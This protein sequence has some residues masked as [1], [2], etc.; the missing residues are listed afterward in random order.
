MCYP[1][2][3]LLLFFV[4]SILVAQDSAPLQTT[5]RVRYV[6]DSSIYIEGGRNAG[7]TEGTKLVIKQSTQK[8]ATDNT[9]KSIEPGIVAEL[10]VVSV[11]ATSA[12][13]DVV[14]TARPIV[15]G[16]EVSLPQ[17]EVQKIV[18]KQTLSNSRQYPAV[19]SFSEGD[20]LDED[21]REK[22]PRP[23][24]PEVNQARGRIG[25]D[26]STIRTI[27]QAQGSSTEVGLVIRADVTRIHGTHWNLNGYWRGRLERSSGGT[28]TLQDQIN[29]TYL[30]GLTY[31]N[32]ESRWSAGVGRLYLPW[33]SSLQTIDGGYIGRKV[34]DRVTLAAFGG[35]TPDPT[36]WNYDP[37]RRIG[38]GLL[39]VQG[40]SFE[41]LW[42][43]SSVGMGMSFL[44]T[45]LDRPFVF[46]E[47][48]FSY[49]RMFSVYHSMQIDRPK[50]N[51]G[52]TPVPMGLGQSFFTLRFQPI[53]R[54]SLDANH[55]YFRDVPTYDP[56]LLGTG[57]LDKYLFQGFSAGAR[58]ELPLHLAAYG[59][60][61][62][63]SNS[64][65]AHTS[66]NSMY[67]LTLQQ[68]WRTGVR[69]DARYSKFDSSFANGTYRSLS[70]ERNFGEL[71]RWNIQFGQQSF[72]SSFSKD[73][74]GR[75]LNSYVD[76]IFGPHYFL[77]SGLTVQRGSTENYNQ[78]TTTVGYRFNNRSRKKGGAIA[79]PQH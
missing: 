68:L 61:G 14:S 58:V 39:N 16:D 44:G 41:T 65:D 53:Q 77:E 4:P 22:M 54:L 12:V 40:G 27:G 63:S 15:E 25:F 43:S 3:W 31:N 2:V 6:A 32:P 26:Y 10:K 9:D 34:S 79:A 74:G 62:Q 5:F 55:T 46:T 52:A 50:A 59:S 17:T 56:Q 1:K 37:N 11:A 28:S 67:G 35:S 78:W 21:V 51:P 19:V 24:L 48:S 13:C 47:N 72:V 57:L 20:P 33:A 75:F 45:T 73:D 49:K 71:F 64:T 23:P 66:L 30:L 76:M 7:L 8:A 69:I 18:D 38:G 70:V 42:Y 29:R 60:L 36:A